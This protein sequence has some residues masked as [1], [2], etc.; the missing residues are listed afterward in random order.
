M[1]NVTREVMWFLAKSV[2]GNLVEIYR[3]SQAGLEVP[4]LDGKRPSTR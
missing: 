1:T 2:V 4:Q 3:P